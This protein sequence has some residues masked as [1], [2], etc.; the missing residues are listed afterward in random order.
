MKQSE[1]DKTYKKMLS[2]LL[3]PVIGIL[4]GWATWVTAQTY[5]AQQ[6]KQ[7]LVQHQTYAAQQQQEIKNDLH[8]LQREVQENHQSVYKILLDLQKQLSSKKR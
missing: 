5:S 6:T 7:E 2:M 1:S 4:I 8:E 3:V